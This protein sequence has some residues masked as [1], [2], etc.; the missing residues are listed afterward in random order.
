[1]GRLSERLSSLLVLTVVL[2]VGAKLVL[3]YSV[4]NGS[5]DGSLEMDAIRFTSGAN[6]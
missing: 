6:Y 5:L 4:F 1:M 2:A 3:L